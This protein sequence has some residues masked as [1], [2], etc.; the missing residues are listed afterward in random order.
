MTDLRSHSPSS[1]SPAIQS[2]VAAQ[3][4]LLT[5][6][7]ATRRYGGGGR[8]GKHRGVAKGR[9]LTQPRTP[10]KHFFNHRSNA[11]ANARLSQSSSSPRSHGNMRGNGKAER[12]RRRP[13][14]QKHG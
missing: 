1:H 11:N 7:L 10:A 13:K 4:N 8:R 9:L 12:Q 14:G 6:Q 3:V 5:F 2:N